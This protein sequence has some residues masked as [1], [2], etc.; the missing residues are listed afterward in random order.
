MSGYGHLSL[1]EREQLCEL[2]ARGFSVRAMAAALGRSASTLSRERARN[3]NADGSYRPLSAERRYLARR[4]R[5]ALLDRLT[6]LASFVIDRLHES[7]TPEQISG[8]LKGDNERGLPPLSPETIHARIYGRTQK[9][10]KLWKLL[11]RRKGC[12]GFRPARTPRT[13][14]KNRRSVHE[15]P[16]CIDER[17]EGGHWEGDLLI[18]R[19]TRPVLVLTERKSRFTVAAK[20][21]G[22]TAQETMTAIMS[23]L[24]RLDPRL[25][26]SI[27]FDNDTAF[28]RHDLLRQALAMTTWFCDAYASWQKGTI[29]NINGRLRRD[30]PRKL[31][32]DRLNETDLQDIV[33]MH[34]LTPRKCLGF[35]TPAQAFLALLGFD[36]KISFNNHVALRV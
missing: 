26:R 22:R 14:I 1:G 24:K 17:D 11:P 4:Q 29:E 16:E 7:W 27:T 10:E 5:P 3:S 30:L 19:K 31:D 12:R 36:A 25:R 23:V 21:A 20:L 18:C 6:E 15:R 13:P 28:A 33:L 8:W 2:R 32:I 34:N 35:K 9:A